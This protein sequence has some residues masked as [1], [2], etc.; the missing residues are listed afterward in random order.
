VMVGPQIN[1][2]DTD[3]P[4]AFTLTLVWRKMGGTWKQVAA[5][6]TSL[7]APNKK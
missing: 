5:Q 2:A 6:Y 1:N 7:P 4:T 3:H